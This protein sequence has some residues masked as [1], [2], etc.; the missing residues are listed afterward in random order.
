MAHDFTFAEFLKRFSS[1]EIC[2][3]EIKKNRYPNGVTCTVCKKVTKHYKVKDR[4]AYLCAVCRHQIFPLKDT[5]FEKT[6]TPLSKWFYA[7]FLMT[8]TRATIS[9][10]KLQTELNVTYKTA[11]RMYTSIKLLMQQNNGDLLINPE[12]NR[13]LRWT[14]L[15]KLEFTVTEK[16]AS[17]TSG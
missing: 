7:M 4:T 9:I 14:F 1:D 17:E 15:N 5:I 13:I 6:T 10:K 11:W 8:Y 12:V 16:K 3:D 2:L